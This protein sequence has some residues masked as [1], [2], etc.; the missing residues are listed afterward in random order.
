[1]TDIKDTI[2]GILGARAVSG[3]RERPK[4]DSRSERRKKLKPGEDSVDISSRARRLADIEN[5][6]S[7]TGDE[8]KEEEEQ[9]LLK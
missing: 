9:K 2:G 7:E 3:D 8:E 4:P 5:F 6:L 1:M